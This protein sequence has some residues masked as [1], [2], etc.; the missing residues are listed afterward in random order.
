[1]PTVFATIEDEDEFDRFR[2]VKDWNGMT[3]EDVVRRGIET[4]D[5]PTQPPEPEP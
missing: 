3:W 1:M 2:K 5:D 4:L